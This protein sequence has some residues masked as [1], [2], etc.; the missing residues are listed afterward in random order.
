MGERL[1]VIAGSGA[2]VP[3]VL[4]AARRQ[5]FEIQLLT[6]G[7]R[8][9][10][11]ALGPI[12]FSLA[13]PQGAI[14]AIRA[15][16]ATCFVMAGGV[17]ISDMARERLRSFFAGG[18]RNGP[19]IGDTGLSN[20]AAE[21]ADLTGARPLGVHQIAPEL[22]A[23]E[24]LIAGPEPTA[25]QR[26]AA[27][28]GLDLAR[29]AGGLDLGQAVVV[30]GRRA[31]AAEDIGGTDALLS[32]VGRL[33]GRGLTADGS[34]PL[35]LAKCA[36]PDQPL[37]VDLPAIGPV[38][39]VKARRAGVGTIVVQAGATLLIGRR[40]LAAAAARTGISV[41]GMVPSDA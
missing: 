6:L 30:A 24:G 27:A 29:R 9:D 15:F 21:L 8:S 32:R 31:V 1:A 39:V 7:R 10:L 2:L 17:S 18:K 40:E 38:T 26:D 13:D 34:S 22:V 12:P 5:G 3:E 16:G 33:R 37:Y 19:T 11:R 35:V 23:E 14:D 28:Y 20:L 25:P 4:A 41:L 36:K